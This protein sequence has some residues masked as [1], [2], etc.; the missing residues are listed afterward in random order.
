MN[1]VPGMMMMASYRFNKRISCGIGLGIEVMEYAA[2]PLFAD[3]K[4]H[5]PVNRSYSPFLYANAGKSMPLG[6]PA[7]S[8]SVLYNYTGGFMSGAGAGILFPGG[9]NFGWYFKAGFRYNEL[10]TEI[11]QTWINRQSMIIHYYHRA[12]VRLGVFFN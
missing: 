12:E 5:L 9:K 3:F 4:L 10:R 6:K 2:A 11:T 7:E 8:F 1:S